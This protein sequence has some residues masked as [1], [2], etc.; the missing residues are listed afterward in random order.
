[1]QDRSP[2]APFFAFLGPFAPHW[3]W[4]IFALVVSIVLPLPF[5][6][7]NFFVFQLTLKWK[8]RL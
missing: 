6:V 1:M 8:N 3:R 7:K 2:L 4:F 5:L